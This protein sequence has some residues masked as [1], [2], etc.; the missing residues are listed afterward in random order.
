MSKRINFF[1]FLGIIGILLFSF[2]KRIYTETNKPD[3]QKKFGI[4]FQA[5]PIPVIGLSLIYNIN[6]KIGIQT[7][8]RIGII[9]VDFF[10]IRLL[11]RFK[12]ENR[13][14]FYTNGLIGYLR[15]DDLHKFL[16]GPEE[17]GEGLEYAAGFGAEYLTGGIFKIGINIEI[18]YLYIDWEEKWFEYSYEDL[19]LI[20][21]GLGVHY[22]F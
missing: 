1:I 13:Y 22:Y 3:T 9:D 17:T 16:L 2:P 5:A 8:G 10:S 19:S 6:K 4:G 7:I 18:D 15:D 11:Y 14:S 12:C 21:L 20:S